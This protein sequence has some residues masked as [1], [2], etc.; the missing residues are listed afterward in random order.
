ML[1]PNARASK[2]YQEQEGRLRPSGCLLFAEGAAA[3]KP[4]PSGPWGHQGA[5]EEGL[6]ELGRMCG[7]QRG[8]SV[9]H[10]L[11]AGLHSG[12]EAPGTSRSAQ[13][14]VAESH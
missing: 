5:S 6:R 11:S 13:C 4:R 14:L 2:D 3:G 1:W 9:T 10:L 8:G 7:L 12:L